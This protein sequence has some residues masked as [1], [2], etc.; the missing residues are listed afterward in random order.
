M[1]KKQRPPKPVPD[2]FAELADLGILPG[3]EVVLEDGSKMVA[4]GFLQ[5]GVCFRTVPPQP[6]GAFVWPAPSTRMKVTRSPNRERAVNQTPEV[7]PL[8]G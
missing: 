3:D 1:A 8:R 7:D 5:G 4:V 2:D 6:Y